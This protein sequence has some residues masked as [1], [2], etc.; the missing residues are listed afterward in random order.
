MIDLVMQLIDQEVIV[1]VLRGFIVI[2]I[3]LIVFRILWKFDELSS[4]V[5]QAWS[6]S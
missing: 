3:W 2:F 5:V 4:S 1:C 6:D